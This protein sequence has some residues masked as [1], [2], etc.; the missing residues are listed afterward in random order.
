MSYI[1]IFTFEYRFQLGYYYDF[2]WR[3]KNDEKTCKICHDLNGKIFRYKPELAHP[4][5]RC[6]LEL[7]KTYI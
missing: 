2:I 1:A 4:N 3:S 6:T 5:C 7:I